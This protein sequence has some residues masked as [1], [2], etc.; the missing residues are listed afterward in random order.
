MPE[1][2]L[3]PRRTPDHKIVTTAIEWRQC[4]KAASFDKQDDTK[5]RA[6]YRARQELRKVIDDAGGQP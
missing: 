5:Q 2:T 4:D 3:N 1:A 6:E